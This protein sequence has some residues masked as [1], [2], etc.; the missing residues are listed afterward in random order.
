MKKG[1]PKNLYTI[2]CIPLTQFRY[3]K[4]TAEQM[5]SAGNEAGLNI[6]II[7]ILNNTAYCFLYCKMN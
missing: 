5:T 3:K 2:R 4:Y 6:K 7:P 1:T